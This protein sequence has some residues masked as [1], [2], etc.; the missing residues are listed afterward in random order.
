M[1]ICKSLFSAGTLKHTRLSGLFPLQYV[2]AVDSKNLTCL[3]CAGN[4]VLLLALPYS[5]GHVVNGDVPLVARTT[6]SLKDNL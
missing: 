3:T 1:D 6:D 5:D 2:P 4:S